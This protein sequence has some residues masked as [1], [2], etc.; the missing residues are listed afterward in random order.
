MRRRSVVIVG[1]GERRQKDVISKCNEEDE[2]DR[3]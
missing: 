2:E 3:K 1:A